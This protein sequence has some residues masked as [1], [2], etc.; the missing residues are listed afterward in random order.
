MSQR[1][2]SGSLWERTANP[3]LTNT[4]SSRIAVFRSRSAE[5]ARPKDYTNAKQHIGQGNTITVLNS[6]ALTLIVGF[7][8]ALRTAASA[9]AP[10]R[11]VESDWVECRR[12]FS[13]LAKNEKRRLVRFTVNEASTIWAGSCVGAIVARDAFDCLDPGLLEIQHPNSVATIDRR[14]SRRAASPCRH[15]HSSRSIGSFLQF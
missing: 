8:M 14:R 6:G 13:T 7:N 15:A 4:R 5:R 9:A 3:I 2:C 12:N 1:S 11:V 10:E